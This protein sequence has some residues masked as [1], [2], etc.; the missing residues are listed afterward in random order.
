M[1]DQH[2]DTNDDAEH[3]QV[4]SHPDSPTPFTSQVLDM[5]SKRFG[6]ALLSAQPAGGWG[7]DHLE[8]KLGKDIHSLH[9]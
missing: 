6:Q 7:I 8:L 2:D 9:L 1:E 5:L 4:S 3:S